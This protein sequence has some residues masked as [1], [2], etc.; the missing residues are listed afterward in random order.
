MAVLALVPVATAA[1]G[2]YV[3]TQD[4]RA[5]AEPKTYP[6]WTDREIKPTGTQYI[7]TLR[8]TYHLADGSVQVRESVVDLSFLLGKQPNCPA[9]P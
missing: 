6:T 3:G 8:C 2:Y 5:T 7:G 9:T 1:I 4:H